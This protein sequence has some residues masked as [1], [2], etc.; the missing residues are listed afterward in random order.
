[1]G[2]LAGINVIEL[3]GIGPG[4]FS[5]MMLSDMGAEVT[6]VDRVSAGAP[7]NGGPMERGKRSVSVNLKEPEGVEV[8]LD[9]VARSDVLL[10][11]FRAGVT[12]RLG[13]GPEAALARNPKLVYARMTG[14]G[15]DGPMAHQ[16][17]HDI[18][19]ISLAGPLAHIGRA[20][21]PPTPPLNLVGDFGGGSL[22]CVLGICAALLHVSRGGEGQVVDSAMVDGA[23]YLMSPM[24][25]A[26]ASGFWTDERGTNFLDSGAHFYDVYECADG[27]FMSVGA[28]EPQFYA[29]LLTGLGLAD[30]DDLADQNDRSQWAAMS[31]RFAAIFVTRTRDEWAEIFNEAEACATPVLTMGESQAHPQAAARGSFFSAGGTPQPFPAPRFLSTPSE[32]ATS[33]EPGAASTDAVLAEL[34]RSPETI[35]D[36]RQRGVVG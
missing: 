27:G 18:N 2:P 23:S 9:L 32:P 33:S 7:K 35:A 12:D 15:Q 31:E 8:V 16:A 3:A 26:H 28:I 34:G 10:E 14:W 36:L 21:Q 4:P 25:A 17:G 19:Y 20:G 5:G 1:M 29:N 13:I 30:A 11:G 6:L 22:F 24:Y